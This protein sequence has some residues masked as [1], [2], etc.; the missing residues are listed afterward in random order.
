MIGIGF[1]SILNGKVIDNKTEVD[2]P[3][4]MF[5]QARGDAS[6]HIAVRFKEETEAIIGDFA[7]LGKAVHAFANFDVHVVI[8]HKLVEI[9]LIHNSGRKHVDWDSHVLVAFHRGSE[10]EVFEVGRD[11]FGAFGGDDTIK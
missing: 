9:V 3:T 5:P 4:R 6:R 8:V 1:V 7:S 10:I 2:R 11:T